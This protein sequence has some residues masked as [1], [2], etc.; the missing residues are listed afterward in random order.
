MENVTYLGCKAIFCDKEGKVLYIDDAVSK[1]TG[2]YKDNV[3]DFE[4][5]LHEDDGSILICDKKI[6]LWCIEQPFFNG[7]TGY[8][9]DN[10]KYADLILQLEKNNRE[11]EAIFES[12]HDGLV[13]ADNKG[14]YIRVSSSYSEI[15]GI[16]KEE[17]LGR[18]ADEIVE[19]GLVSDAATSHVL[20]T[21]KSYSFSQVFKTGRQSIITG[22]P[23]YNNQNEMISVVTNVR[24]MT[25]INKL[26][27][28][29]A[30]SREKLAHYTQIV[31]TLTEERLTDENFV[32]KSPKME[33][34]MKAALKFSKVDAAILI[35]GESG[36]GKELVADFIYRNS[37]R[38]KSPFLKINCG[39]IPDTLLEAELFGYEGGAFTGAKK[40]GHTGLFKLADNGTILLDEISELSMP[41]QVKLLRFVQQKEFYRVGGDKLIKVNVRIIAA[42]NRDLGEMVKQN[43]F[44]S[45]LFYRLDVLKINIPPL[46][47]RKEDIIP[48]M[49]HFLKK[50][51]E[52]YQTDKLFTK[53]IYNLFLN[54]S[55][56]GNIRELENL[57]ERLVLICEQD[58]ITADYLPEE[59]KQPADGQAD[60]YFHD[61]MTYK[62]AR[63]E[64]EINFLK[65][66][67]EKYKTVRKAAEKLGVDHSTI[68][69]KAAKY[70]IVLSQK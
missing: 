33:H 60:I 46:R 28:K 23:V 40:S 68:V 1:E 66:S 64:F 67:I 42:T 27:I 6:R 14:L 58:E 35:T 13:V 59:F 19:K 43:L 54:Y 63:D 55:W 62:E 48:L 51:N 10:K 41:L 32:Y 20:Q 47:E 26:R 39:A 30:A 15:S 29:L 65:K 45:D 9:R 12:S 34:M 5:A 56:R 38:K 36:V 17:I 7:Y 21:G 24:D 44:R 50:Y 25:E 53:E 8:Y 22:S 49:L 61:E 52:K 3:A 16:P 69:K 70:G 31:E 2:L 4:N 18:T 11:L 57:I 37:K